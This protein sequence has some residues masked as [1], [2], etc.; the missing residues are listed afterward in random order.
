MIILNNKC[1]MNGA[2]CFVQTKFDDF[3]H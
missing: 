1:D 3:Q 2:I